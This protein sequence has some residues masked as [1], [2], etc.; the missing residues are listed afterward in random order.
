M[1]YEAK[2]FYAA[3]VRCWGAVERFS[4]NRNRR[5]ESALPETLHR[6]GFLLPANAGLPDHVDTRPAA[7]SHS[8]A[9]E[10]DHREC[11]PCYAHP[12]AERISHCQGSSISA[13]SYPTSSGPVRPD[14][15]R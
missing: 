5:A 8:C 9:D 10:L 6:A 13:T 4:G 1:G 7:K 12:C 15:V 2:V 11:N 3:T 14:S